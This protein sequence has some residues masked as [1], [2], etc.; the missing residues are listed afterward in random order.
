MHT[1]FGLGGAVIDASNAAQ[2]ASASLSAAAAA[3][4]SHS[5]SQQGALAGWY[6]AYGCDMDVSQLKAL[7]ISPISTAPARVEGARLAFTHRGGQPNL[8]PPPDIA[9]SNT[10]QAAPAGQ[11]APHAVHGVLVGLD[12]QGLSRLLLSQH[13]RLPVEVA[14]TPYAS[15]SSGDTGS[16]EAV[17]AACGR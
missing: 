12:A 6:F 4:G 10:Q 9:A 16:T 15:S 14:V 7:G 1:R 11:A 5:S 17:W 8:V 13:E 3:P 2:Q